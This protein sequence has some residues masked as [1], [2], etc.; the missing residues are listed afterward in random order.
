MAEG[1]KRKRVTLSITQKLQLIDILERGVSVAHVCELYGVK[2][3][4]VSDIRKNKEKLTQFLLKY[5]LNKSSRSGFGFTA[6]DRKH[7]KS[8][9]NE[10]LEEAVYKWFVQQRSSGVVVRSV[11]LR[12]AAEKLSEHMGIAFRASDGWLWRF[13]KRHGI[14]NRKTSGESLSADI[15][16]V[17]PSSLLVHS[18]LRLS[19]K[20]CQCYRFV[21]FIRNKQKTNSIK[22]LCI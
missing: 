16:R 4:T 1:V 3:Q 15:D 12:A 17:E 10:N 11:E 5:D 8:A 13:R 20:L 7:V 2:K 19:S 14:S 18:N 21:D 6:R 22:A 9:Q